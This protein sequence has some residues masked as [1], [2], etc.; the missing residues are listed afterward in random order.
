MGDRSET[1]SSI[2]EKLVKLDYGGLIII[3]AGATVLENYQRLEKEEKQKQ[4]QECHLV[5]C[6]SC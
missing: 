5:R 6:V 3:H 2:I 4:E 1:M